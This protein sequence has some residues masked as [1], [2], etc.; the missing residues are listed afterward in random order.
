[1][2][3]KSHWPHV[4][5]RLKVAGMNLPG[6]PANDRRSVPRHIRDGE[7]DSFEDTMSG[8]PPAKAAR[9]RWLLIWL[10]V[11]ALAVGLVAWFA[12]RPGS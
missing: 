2:W 5:R 6:E 11:A 9:G 8:L 12:L 1:M 3:I 10:V 7:H 4:A